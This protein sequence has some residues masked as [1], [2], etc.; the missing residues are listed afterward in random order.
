MVISRVRE[1]DDLL[2][3]L[4]VSDRDIILNTLEEL[5]LF[6]R[7]NRADNL[8]VCIS[9]QNLLV[10]EFIDNHA[11]EL[12]KY[13]LEASKPCKGLYDEIVS[14]EYYRDDEFNAYWWDMLSLIHI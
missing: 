13:Y 6:M 9:L 10:Y 2:L 12:T 1:L 8:Y 5:K 11:Y 7:D 14:N 4:K 3:G